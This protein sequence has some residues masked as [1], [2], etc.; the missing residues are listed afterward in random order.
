METVLQ[1]IPHVTVYIDDILIT[2]KSDVDHLQTL[3]TVLERLA[4]AGLRAKKNKCKF[5]V[6]SVDYLGYVID[7]QG[8]GHSAG[9]YAFHCDPV[10]IVLGSALVLRKIPCKFVHSASPTVQVTQKRCPVEMVVSAGA[11]ISSI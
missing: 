3:E 9:T 4:K 6:P 10:E 1:G 2:G 11:R 7:A 8:V 5:M